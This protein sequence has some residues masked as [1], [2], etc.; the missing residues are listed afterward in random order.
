MALWTPASL[1][2]AAAWYIADDSSNTSSGGVTTV[3][4]DKTGRGNHGTA[5]HAGGSSATTLNSR[6]TLRSDYGGGVFT[7]SDAGL[8]LG[9]NNDGISFFIVHKLVNSSSSF[10]APIGTCFTASNAIHVALMRSESGTGWSAGSVSMRT[11]PTSGAGGVEIGSGTD[12]GTGWMQLG[13]NRNFAGDTG[14]IW[15]DGTQV[16]SGTMSADPSTSA[17]V[18]TLAV[19]NYTGA[20]IDDSWVQDWAEAVAVEGN[21]SDTDRQKIEGYL[22]WQWGLQG[23]LPSGHPY[24]SA[25]PTT[26]ATAEIVATQTA[27]ATAQ[28]AA[29]TSTAGFAAGGDALIASVVANLHFNG[30][31]GST[32][33]TDDN[34]HAFS[35]A[36]TAALSTAQARFGSASLL[37]AGGGGATGVADTAWEPGSGDFCYEGFAYCTSSA[38]LQFLLCTRNATGQDWG[39]AV[40]VQAGQIRGFC[41]NTSAAAFADTGFGGAVPANTWFHWAY[42]RTG[43][44]FRMALNGITVASVTATGTCGTGTPLRIGYDPSNSSRAFQGYIDEV[45]ITKGSGRYAASFE[46]PAFAFDV[47]Y[48]LAASTTQVATVTAVA[49]IPGDANTV[50]V[51]HLDGANG[52]TAIADAKGTPWTAMGN[53]QISTAQSMAGGAS[54]L[55]DGDGDYALSPVSPRFGFGTGDF[56]VECFA[57]F[58][59]APSGNRFIFDARA[60]S[61]NS[62]MLWVSQ[63]ANP[64]KLCWSNEGGTGFVVG[65]GA[66]GTGAWM[67]IAITRQGG[68]V[69]GYANGALQFTTTDARDYGT[70]QGILLGSSAT[71]NQGLIGN[72]DEFR[73]TK[74]VAL[75]TGSSYT[76]PAAPYADAANQQTAA[77]TTQAATLAQPASGFLASQT[78]AAT[79]Q[80]AA[81]AA[82]AAIAAAQTASPTTQ[83]ATLVLQALTGVVANQTAA[84]TS[85]VA[86]FGARAGVS[87]AQTAQVTTQAAV[88]AMLSRL[89]AAQTAQATSQSAIIGLPAGSVSAAQTADAT[90]QA[91]AMA[92]AVLAIAAA[93]A[94][95][96]TTQIARLSREYVYEENVRTMFI[97]AQDRSY[98]LRSQQRTT[99]PVPQERTFQVNP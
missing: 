52:S 60:T 30:S 49:S 16:A 29:A 35:V 19:G 14:A 67:H 56:T 90:S 57:R 10:P 66:L 73:V 94:A 42:T 33:I 47:P 22:A 61:G 79:A 1:T 44:T 78:A 15:V 63:S 86:T 41:G 87:A 40:M 53:A 12:Y 8:D 84:P 99:V 48:Q 34:G 97:A 81:L 62:W 70:Q 4:A 17:E 31:N 92:R 85:Q 13:C 58:S 76:P 50:S 80:A 6:S 3:V 37:P 72:I 18:L 21:I 88:L 7:S 36:G 51:L 20:S 55:L 43:S 45:R 89:S 91:A 11:R 2:T 71:A 93:Q 24:K 25:A 28:V 75:Y 96:T 83:L 38:A 26:G 59:T 95:A 68:T 77:P 23:N 69:R 32:T 74:G 65:S 98:L 5:S 39:P 54:L 82:R 64:G 46:P 9:A 27:A